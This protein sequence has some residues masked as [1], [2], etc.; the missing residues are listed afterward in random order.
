MQLSNRG[1]AL[2][3]AALQLAANNRAARGEAQPAPR[4]APLRGR[5]TAAAI[6]R[7]AAPAPKG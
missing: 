5:R 1:I 2:A 7:R 6:K 3:T 4:N